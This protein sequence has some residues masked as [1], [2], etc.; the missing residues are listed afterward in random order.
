MDLKGKDFIETSV[1]I[2]RCV[3]P[4]LRATVAVTLTSFSVAEML[5]TC[6]TRW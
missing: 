3:L 5:T 2:G 4:T 6:Q 1:A